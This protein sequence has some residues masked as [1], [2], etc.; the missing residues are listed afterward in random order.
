MMPKEKV[1]VIVPAYNEEKVLE[2]NI[3]RLREILESILDDY[4]III[5]E[6]GSTDSTAQIARSIECSTIRVSSNERR[7]GKGAAI[8]CAAS[9]ATGSLMLFMDA[10]LASDPSQVKQLVEKLNDGADVVIGSRYLRESKAQRSAVRYFASRSFNTLVRLVLGSK[11]SDHQCGFKAF[12]KE[13]ALPIIE[14]VENKRWFW[15]TEFLVRAQR[16]GLKVDEIPIAWKESDGS[17][18]RLFQDTMH[19]AYSLFSFK[20]KNW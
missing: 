18:Y 8:K 11:I 13:T 4:E 12:R 19:M 5:S 14:Q 6:D 20:L 16:K 3:N 1:S 17:K 10:D 9:K 7:M 2:R 15:D